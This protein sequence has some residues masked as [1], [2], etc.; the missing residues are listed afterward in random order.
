MNG[1]CHKLGISYAY[2]KNEGNY[3]CGDKI[4][5]ILLGSKDISM[6]DKDSNDVV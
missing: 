4:S 5:H 1:S 6:L 3:A 2:E